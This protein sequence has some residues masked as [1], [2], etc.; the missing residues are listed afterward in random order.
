MNYVNRLER[1]SALLLVGMEDPFSYWLKL[2]P[3]LEHIS[4][5]KRIKTTHSNCRIDFAFTQKDGGG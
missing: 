3:I 4:K 1:R 5:R 2:L